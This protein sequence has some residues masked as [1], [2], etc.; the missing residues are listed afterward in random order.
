MLGVVFF[1]N[2]DAAGVLNNFDERKKV[3]GLWL[4]VVLIK[5]L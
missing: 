3:L 5:V 1:F 2:I 4:W